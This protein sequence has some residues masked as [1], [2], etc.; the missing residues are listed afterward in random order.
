VDNI[1]VI[2]NGN[3]LCGLKWF[4]LSEFCVN[5]VQPFDFTVVEVC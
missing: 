3:D 5:Y 1:C 4:I 2:H